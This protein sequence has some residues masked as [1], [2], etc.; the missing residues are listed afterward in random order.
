[1]SDLC[2]LTNRLGFRWR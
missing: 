2:A 1:M